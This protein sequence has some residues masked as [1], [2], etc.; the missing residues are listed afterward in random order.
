MDRDPEPRDGYAQSVFDATQRYIQ[1]ILDGN[2]QV[3]RKLAALE[4]DNA[5]LERERLAAREEI[6]GLRERLARCR[7]DHAELQRRLCEVE[8]ESR[9]YADEYLDLER[10]N[11]NLVN[12]YVA[13]Y[14]LHGTLARPEI[15]QCIREIVINLIG[16]EELAVLEVEGDRFRTADSFG[17]DDDAC[18]G[19]ST[20][21]GLVGRVVST[22]EP[23]IEGRS[24]ASE[25]TGSEEY[26]TACIPLRVEDRVFGA[27]AI[28]RLLPQKSAGLVDL[29]HELLE[30][31]AAQAGTALFCSTLFA[32][33]A[34]EERRSTGTAG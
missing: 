33:H 19:L 22:G 18:E 28:F 13:S 16:S 31:L 4:S 21:A 23:W 29:D 7:E 11:S 15:L 1:K 32:R 20:E 25:R 10:R 8:N 30:L 26:L 5:A 24:D 9:G 17:I 12:L 6:V 3:R 34:A 27:I 2:D 14:G